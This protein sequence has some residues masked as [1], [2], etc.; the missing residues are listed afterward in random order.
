MSQRIDRVKVAAAAEFSSQGLLYPRQDCNACNVIFGV[1]VDTHTPP[2]VVGCHDRTKTVIAAIRQYQVSHVTRLRI[3]SRPLRSRS[4]LFL[5][6][7][8]NINLLIVKRYIPSNRCTLQVRASIAPNDVFE[9]FALD[10]H[11]II[12]CLPLCSFVLSISGS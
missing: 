8:P 7:D 5:S 4:R 10:V 6:I 1:V 3:R 12:M 9:L 11:I 2:F